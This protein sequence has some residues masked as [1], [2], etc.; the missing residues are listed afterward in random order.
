MEAIITDGGKFV[1]FPYCVSLIIISF[2][3]SSEVY[4][5][6]RGES[7]L[8]KGWGYA[9]LSFFL[10]WW[11]FPFGL[12]FTPITLFQTLRGGN[13]VTKDMMDALLPPVVAAPVGGAGQPRNPWS[14]Q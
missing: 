6:R 11:G 12:I 5:I 9:V 1:V 10:G 8:A 13:D 7:A 4:L 14:A 2:R 3:R